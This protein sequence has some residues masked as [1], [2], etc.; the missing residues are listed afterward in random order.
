MPFSNIVHV[1]DPSDNTFFKHSILNIDFQYLYAVFYNHN[2][3]F[4]YFSKKISDPL[5]ETTIIC[6]FVTKTIKCQ[7]RNFFDFAMKLKK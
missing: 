1:W 7:E 2:N 5:H 4:L 6:Q 3:I